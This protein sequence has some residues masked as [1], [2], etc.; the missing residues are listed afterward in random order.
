[1]MELQA[2]GKSSYGG[3]PAAECRQ[4]IQKGLEGMHAPFFTKIEMEL[5]C[6]RITTPQISGLQIQKWRFW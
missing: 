3:V 2:T 6:L 4:M 1:M 5:W